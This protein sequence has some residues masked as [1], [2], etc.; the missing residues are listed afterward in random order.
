MKFKFENIGDIAVSYTT[1]I[2]RVIS[3]AFRRANVLKELKSQTNF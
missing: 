3:Y 1:I 2:V